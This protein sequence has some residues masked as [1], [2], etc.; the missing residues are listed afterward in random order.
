M[1][2]APSLNAVR[3][4]MKEHPSAICCILVAPNFSRLGYENIILRFGYLD[5][6]TGE[7]IH[8]YCAGYGGYWNK[9]SVPDMTDIG[10]GKYEG[11]T[12][13]PWAFSQRLFGAFVNELEEETRW[14]Y[15][16]GS[17]IIILEPGVGFSRCIVFK[18][19][20]MIADEIIKDP[21]ELFEALIQHARTHKKI[22]GFSL[23]NIGTIS[24]EEIVNSVI[25]LLPKPFENLLN[26]WKK[27]KHYTLV[28][29]S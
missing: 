3:N 17:E 9:G 29:I 4:D 26:I 28:D 21:G 2:E 27:G 24:G 20:S 15:S 14:K 7:D 16:G 13:I 19:D 18:L 25:S 8:F 6:R 1:L 12:V 22:G 10:I 23:K 11:G 5:Y